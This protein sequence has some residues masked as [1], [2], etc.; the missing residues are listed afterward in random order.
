[1]F[2]HYFLAHIDGEKRVHLDSTPHDSKTTNTVLYSD[3]QL[4]SPTKIEHY[5]TRFLETRKI[6]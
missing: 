2:K 6:R 5:I 4:V 1:M 3:S